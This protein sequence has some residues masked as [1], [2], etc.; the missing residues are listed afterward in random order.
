MGSTR[1]PYLPVIYPRTRCGLGLLCGHN[2]STAGVVWRFQF[3][4]VFELLKE[5]SL[6]RMYF[7]ISPLQANIP[8]LS[9][10]PRDGFIVL[11]SLRVMSGPRVRKVGQSADVDK[12]RV[13]TSA[14][15]RRGN[16]KKKWGPPKGPRNDV[17]QKRYKEPW[18]PVKVL[19]TAVGHNRIGHSKHPP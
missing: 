13:G 16:N 10:L 17:G 18:R 6:F 12:E 15:G 7:H 19:A 4:H 5:A 1:F 8:L 3:S 2:H 9:A 11:E 14:C